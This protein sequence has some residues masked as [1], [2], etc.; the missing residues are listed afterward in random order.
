[1]IRLKFCGMRSLDDVAIC[2]AAGADALG[3]IFADGPRRLTIDEAARLAAAVPRGVARVGVF[4]DQPQAL[5]E[6]ALS[7][8]RLD[9]LQF[10]GAE[11][12]EFCGSFGMPTMLTARVTAPAPDVV[13]RARATAIIVDAVVD[14]MYG[15]TGVRVDA[16]VARRIRAGTPT[17]LIL[18]GGL[19]PDNVGDAIRAV[20]PDGVDV[21]S[22]VERDGRKDSEL[23][24]AFAHA[25]EEAYAARTR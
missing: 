10:A 13:A 15:G 16:V 9:V 22:G 2:A 11:S 14:G 24:R 3:F 8:C 23:V 7:A 6:A 17:R 4:A 20:A 18:A 5:V 1:M 12:A 25:V 21:R 19:T